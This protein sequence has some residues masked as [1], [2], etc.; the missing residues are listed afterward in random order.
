MRNIRNQRN[1][2]AGYPLTAQRRLLLQLIRD[3]GGHVDAKEL[4]RRASSTDESISLATVYRSLRLFQEL[5][6]VEERRFGQS[7]HYYEIRQP[8]EHQHFVCRV[9]GK[10]IEFQNPLIEQL[11]G[12]LQAEQG[13][14]VTKAEL[15]LEGYCHECRMST[16][17]DEA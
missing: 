16:E 11:I 15:Y 3:T 17:R 13:F 5:G 12:T 10:I 14:S 7:S 2:I 6:L 1:E 8:A 9:C 4:Y